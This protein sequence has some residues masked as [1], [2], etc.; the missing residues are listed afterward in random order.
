MTIICQP[1]ARMLSNEPCS[2]TVLVI[3]LLPESLT[4]P[5]STCSLRSRPNTV[6]NGSSQLDAWP[7]PSSAQKAF[8]VEAS[9]KASPLTR[10]LELDLISHN[11]TREVRDSESRLE[12][13]LQ[14]DLGL[15]T[16]CFLFGGLLQEACR[17]G[18]GLGKEPLSASHTPQ[19]NFQSSV[20]ALSVSK[21]IPHPH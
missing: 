21:T 3:V 16:S 12:C 15:C 8:T 17:D 19:D 18:S 13:Q 10:Y 9:R 20:S 5:P 14:G 11:V 6:S 7:W 1:R 2:A 4:Q